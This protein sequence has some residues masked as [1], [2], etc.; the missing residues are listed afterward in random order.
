MAAAEVKLLFGRYVKQLND[1]HP[2]VFN[3]L[4]SVSFGMTGS[5]LPQKC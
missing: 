3:R 2:D 1:H 5:L 4:L